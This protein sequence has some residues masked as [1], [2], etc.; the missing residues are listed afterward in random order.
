MTAFAPN[1]GGEQ[2]GLLKSKEGNGA[3]RIPF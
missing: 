1:R 2:T 3:G